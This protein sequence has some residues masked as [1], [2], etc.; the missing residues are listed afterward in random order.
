MQPMAGGQT[1]TDKK[2]GNQFSGSGADGRQGIA[3]NWASALNQQIV[4]NSGFNSS[5]HRA[6][7]N[8]EQPMT[9]KQG[10]IRRS[11]HLIRR[12]SVMSASRLVPNESLKDEGVQDVSILVD[13]D[14]EEQKGKSTREEKESSPKQKA[15]QIAP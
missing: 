2:K 10:P 8:F 13:L 1:N 6:T 14:A 12:S 3:A 7:Q 9:T 15:K 4:N 5:R 11:S